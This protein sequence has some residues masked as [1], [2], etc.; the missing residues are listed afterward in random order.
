M[1]EKSIIDTT[2]IEKAEKRDRVS[3]QASGLKEY[4]TLDP[5]HAE[6]GPEI[7]KAEKQKIK[8]RDRGFM[9]AV[10]LI[11]FSV[12]MEISILYFIITG[13]NNRFHVAIVVAP[14]I[15]FTTV[16][17]AVLIGIF[18][19]YNNKDTNEVPSK[20]INATIGIE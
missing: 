10:T 19:G 2:A 14:I 7:I 6:L 16:A 20:A 18:R 15:S 3:R 13:D 12:V 8:L 4:Y 9:L 17:I 5:V 1:T 11:V